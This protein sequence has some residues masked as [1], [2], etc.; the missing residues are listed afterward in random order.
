MKLKLATIMIIA[1]AVFGV[2]RADSSY[3]PFSRQETQVLR[4]VWSEIR[5]ARDFGDI[6]WRAVGLDDPPGDFEAQRVMAEHWS[7][8]RTARDFADVDWR[9]IREDEDREAAR[10]EGPVHRGYSRDE[11]SVA[12]DYNDETGPFTRDEARALREV[13]SEIRDA[14]NY[15]DIDWRAVG[16]ARAPGDRYAREFMAQDWDSLR[17]AAR[18]DDID[19]RAEYRRH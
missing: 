19:W 3:S 6:D 8:V 11:G 15:D 9:A 5:Q 14:E 4:S 16:L 10:D 1:L 12:R 13:W 2:A 7:R 18:F 17:R